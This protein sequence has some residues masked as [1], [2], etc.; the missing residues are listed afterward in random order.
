MGSTPQD[1]PRSTRTRFQDTFSE[2]VWESTYKDHNDATIDDTLKRVAKFV[3]EAETTPELQAEWYKKFYDMLTDFKCTSGGRI[4]SNAGTEWHGTTLMNCFTAD[5]QVL[6]SVGLK[7]I[8]DVEIGDEVL[9]HMG[10][11]R[12]VV[13][14]LRRPYDGLV[15]R[16]ASNY[17]TKDIVSTPEH[18]YYQGD[19][20]W[21][22]SEDVEF[23]VTPT[24]QLEA[25]FERKY[26]ITT[27]ETPVYDQHRQSQLISV[28]DTIVGKIPAE[29]LIKGDVIQTTNKF[30]AGNGAVQTK[31]SKRI[32]NWFTFTESTAYLFGRFVGDGC[33]FTN[34]KNCLGD[35][36]AFTIAFNTETEQDAITQVVEMFGYFNGVNVSPGGDHI[37]VCRPNVVVSQNNTTYVR[38]ASQILATF[39]REICGSGFASKRVPEKI[40]TAR[41]SVQLAFLRGLF[42]ADGF[43]TSRGQLGLEMT[44]PT[45]MAE[46]QA[47]LTVVGVPATLNGNRLSAGAGTTEN[48]RASLSKVYEDNRLHFVNSKSPTTGPVKHGESFKIV[49]KI[50]T[51]Q[52]TG[53]VYNIS[54]E[55]DESY[56]V[57]NVVVHNCFVSPR[58]KHDI[59]SLS[60][61]LQNVHNQTQTLKSEGGWG[62]NF[63]YIR[64]RGA[65]IH[66]IGVETPGA[67]KYM[68]L[69]DKSSDIITAGSGKKSKNAKAKGKIRK[70]AM[71]GVLD[72]WHPDIVEFITAKQ[73]SGRLSKFNISVNCSDEFMATVKRVSE[74]KTQGAS[75]EEIAAVDVWE[76]RFPDTLFD[77]YKAEW[78]GDMKLWEEKGYPTVVHNTVS[79]MW[80]WNLIMESTYN[81][82]EPGVLFLDRA[83]HFAPLNYAE[84]IY[85]TNPSMPAGTLV[86][87]K[88]GIV[89]IDTLEGQTFKVKSMDGEWADAKCF[90]S[91]NNEPLIEFGFGANRTTKSTKEH[92]WPVYDTRMKRV[93][94]AYAHELKVGDMIP[95][96]RNELPGIEGNMDLTRDQGLFLGYLVGDG[97]VSKRPD[98]TLTAGLT[99]GN[100]ERQQAE[101][102]LNIINSL[103]H[104]PSTIVEKDTGEL[105]IQ[106]SSHELMNFIV[107]VCGWDVDQ[108]SK[109]IPAGVWT[110][111][112][113]F[114]AGFVD[115][116]YS[117][118]GCVTFDQK[119]NQKLTLT[120]S[121]E[122]LAQDFAKLLSF[123]GVPVSVWTSTNVSKFPNQHDYG[124]EYTCWDVAIHGRA[125][126]NFTNVFDL[127]HSGKN[128]KLNHATVWV[129]ENKK[130]S[131]QQ[132]FVTI[133]SIEAAPNEPVWDI[134][135][136]HNQH[137][138][139]SQW[140]YTGNCGEQMLAPGG[141]C[142]LG[143]LNLTQ[144]LNKDRTGFDLKKL[145]KYARILVRFLDNINTM[146]AAP[147]P[148]YEDSMR[149]KRRIGCGILGWGSALYMLKVRFGSDEA[150]ELREQVMS[151]IAREAYMASIDLA[152][153][154]GMFEYCDPAKHAEGV[155]INGL[156]LPEAYMEKVR[157]VGIRNSSVL[158]IQPTGNTS[159]MAN[160]VSGGLEPVFMHEYVRTV[161]V[162][163]MPE[164]IADVCPKW[165]EGEWKETEL[166]KFAKEGDEE[167]LRGEHNGVVYKI[168]TNRGLTREVLC[169]D[170][171]VRFMKGVGEW[172]PSADW[173]VTTTSLA[174]E[175]HVSDLKGF[176]RWVDSAMSKTVNV[177]N[178]YGFEAFKEIYTDAYNSGFVK[179]ITTYRSGTMTSVLSAKDEKDL[180]PDFEEEVILES[181]KLPV[182]APATVKTLK[183][184]NKKWYLTTILN[185]QQTRPVA[186][187]VHT[188]A[189]EASA[190]THDATDRLLKLAKDKGIPQQWIDDTV[191]KIRGSNNVTKIARTISLNLRHGVLIKNIVAQLEQIDDVFVGSFL[192]QIKK[193][194][195]S[196]IKDGEKVVGVTCTECGSDQVVYQEG[197]FK[198][199]S[200]GSSKCG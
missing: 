12:P 122:T 112:D 115:G 188:N 173:A 15:Q 132:D 9:T 99:F 152:E 180:A 135:V 62:E 182:S 169:E 192:F 11:F 183:A 77:K 174:V 54:V 154:K 124:K 131:A 191:D 148:E 66:G 36:D 8:C 3:A 156:D 70:G 22:N 141:V 110:S 184:E 189:H 68:E 44:N 139:P 153:E 65:F 56:V 7:N 195:A 151:T 194:L 140:C 181:I 101:C 19:G 144:F 2:E 103:K 163:S 98:G 75:E 63:S 176:A 21:K 199:M 40:W 82:A 198:C 108:S 94:K 4:Y 84:T 162:N 196:Y 76:L 150:D 39:F 13:N 125:L 20:E 41:Q 137:V 30:V 167:I 72:V 60:S 46:V 143:S 92:R 157:T 105:C 172:D 165:Y 164:E 109:Q 187:F 104:Q 159:I 106:W 48:F 10:R 130:A 114:I 175:D 136:A 79:A 33:T 119:S 160:V 168:D 161:I 28:Y 90:L 31:T 14:V 155:F 52:Y 128:D 59:D 111:N 50:T 129:V 134:S 95:L 81:R 5:A 47:L 26:D 117:S 149:K 51:E 29:N 83:N 178:E 166:F 53:D 73:Q 85:A 25:E 185:E 45:L 71:M 64:P 171:G 116:L 142:N 91:S 86:G 74:L 88:D 43:V 158:S 107:D 32:N 127:T 27:A 96:N 34:N 179:G 170:Y 16:L 38:M 126:I 67:V 55:E 193:F 177:P 118:D 120:T 102:L 138:F 97:W 200:C 145:A 186:L 37:D 93:Y 100:H 23:V 121:S 133:R 57:N 1:K 80:L 58:A 49:P 69:F 18:P 89:P 78:S 146:S 147:L 24:N 17:F 197:C 61:I 190:T 6:T 35:V 123:A 87:T 113:Q 42:D